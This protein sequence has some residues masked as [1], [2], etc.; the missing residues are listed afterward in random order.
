MLLTFS[1]DERNGV[2]IAAH[3]CVLLD[4]YKYQRQGELKVSFASDYVTANSLIV[5]AN[6][7]WLYIVPWGI[8]KASLK[9]FLYLVSV[10]IS[11]HHVSF[12]NFV[13]FLIIH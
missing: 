8:N 7:Y 12:R 2:P 6:S 3:A 5:Q 10:S 1:A 11:F 4:A 9:I 13:L